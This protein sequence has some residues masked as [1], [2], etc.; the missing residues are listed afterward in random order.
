LTDKLLLPEE[1][2]ALIRLSEP[3]IYRLRRKGKFPAPI[4][5]G[6]KRIAYRESEITAWIETRARATYSTEAA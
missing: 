4:M 1:V 6:E 5:L 3:T 2:R